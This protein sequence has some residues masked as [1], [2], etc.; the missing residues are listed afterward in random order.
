MSKNKRAISEVVSYV[1][2]IIL[3]LSLAVFV[4]NWLRGFVPSMNEAKCPD[5]ISLIIRDQYYDQDS[6]NL[7][8]T[9]QN[10]GRFSADG[11]YVRVNNDTE[12]NFGIY[13][14]DKTGIKIKVGEQNVTFFN[15]TNYTLGNENFTLI[16]PLKVVEIQPYVFQKGHAGPVLCESV[17]RVSLP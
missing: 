4:F 15:S 14:L 7:T 8:L 6:R 5:G 13:V 16:Q 12:P 1:L 17:S 10:R 2:L 9:I 11:F 3:S